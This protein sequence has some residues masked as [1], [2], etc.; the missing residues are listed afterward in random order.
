MRKAAVVVFSIFLGLM[1][2]LLPVSVYADTL[3]PLSPSDQLIK[4]EVETA[5]S[6]LHAIFKKYRQGEMGL[7]EAKKLG[8]DLLRELRYGADGYFWA[9]TTE[10][11][12]VVLYGQK[13]VEGKNRLEAK[14]K[15]GVFYIKAFIAKG[16]TGGYVEYLFP[17]KG[18]TDPQ[19]KRSY[20][21]LFEPFG[22]IIGTGYYR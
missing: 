6:M 22:W 8:A 1:S 4:S 19:P 13:D 2:L 11:V 15:N 14:D 12:N 16:K 10:G 17:K 7:D 3:E 5:H 21:L 18:E 9:D 20:V